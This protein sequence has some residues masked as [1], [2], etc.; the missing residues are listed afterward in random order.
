VTRDEKTHKARLAELGCMLCR[1]LFGIQDGP[2]EL[3]HR[4]EGGW[5]RGDYT[6]LIPM[7]AEHHRGNSGVHG[8]GTKAFA[9]RYGVTQQELLDDALAL[10]TSSCR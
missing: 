8:L 5:G 2:V 10:L 7:C 3:H 9:R 1:R 4:R 6:T